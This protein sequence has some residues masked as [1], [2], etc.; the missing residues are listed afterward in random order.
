MLLQK[1]LY[2]AFPLVTMEKLF[3]L[4]SKVYSFLFKDTSPALTLF[5][6]SVFH[7][8]W[9]SLVNIKKKKII[10][11]IPHTT[12]ILPPFSH[13]LAK[14]SERVVHTTSSCF[15]VLLSLI[16]SGFVSSPLR[17]HS[18]GQE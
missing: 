7:L 11:L 1:C 16:R 17:Q 13:F 15:P 18:H 2:T 10:V 12:N 9:N 5:S 8:S 6:S 14:L 3:M 4:L